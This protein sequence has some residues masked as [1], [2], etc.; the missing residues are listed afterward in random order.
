MKKTWWF[1]KRLYIKGFCF[2]CRGK[3]DEWVLNNCVKCPYLGTC[4]KICLWY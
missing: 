2:M 3:N 4:I 1:V